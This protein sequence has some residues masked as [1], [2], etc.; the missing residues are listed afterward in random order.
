MTKEVKKSTS[1]KKGNKSK[2]MSNNIPDYKD[3]LFFEPRKTWEDFIN[4]CN[5]KSIEGQIDYDSFGEFVEIN[6]LKFYKSGKIRIKG[7][8]GSISKDRNFEQFINVIND[9]FL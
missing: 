6:N 1:K 2:K 4:Y 9:M 7:M 5:N 8:I 3:D